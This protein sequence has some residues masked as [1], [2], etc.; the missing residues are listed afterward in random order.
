M[1]IDQNGVAHVLYSD[2][3]VYQVSTTDASCSASGSAPTGGDFTHFG[4]GFSADGPE[5]ATETLFVV[6][7]DIIDLME[8]QDP[9]LASLDTTTHALSP[10]GTLS[11]WVELSGNRAGEL[12][13]FRPSN[14]VFSTITPAR[15]DRLDKSTGASLEGWDLDLMT[16]DLRAWAFAYWGARFYIFIQEDLAPSSDVWR[17]TPETGEL[18]RVFID[19]ARGITGAGVSICAPVT[20]I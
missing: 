11:D 9:L 18:E 3:R 10:I 7:G 2:G 6:G 12:Y 20:L 13:T 17:F 15:V 14:Q 8:D 5:S 1:S 16:G 19:V 4:M